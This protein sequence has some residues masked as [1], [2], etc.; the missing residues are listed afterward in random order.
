MWCSRRRRDALRSLTPLRE[1]RARNTKKRTHHTAADDGDAKPPETVAGAGAGATAAACL[2]FA[3][4]DV[5]TANALYAAYGNNDGEW[6][7]C[8]GRLAFTIFTHREESNDGFFNSP[9]F[10]RTEKGD[11]FGFGCDRRYS[12]EIEV[13]FL[14]KL[15]ALSLSTFIFF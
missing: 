10:L 5:R 3:A 14:Q 8:V 2:R 1:A 13:S 15:T 4:R 6:Q 12:R 9:S 11:D 7:P